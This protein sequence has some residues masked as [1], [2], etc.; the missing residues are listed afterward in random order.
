MKTSASWSFEFTKLVVMSPDRIFYLMKWQST[1]VCLVLSWKSR[2]E[3]MCSAAWL[4]QIS[5]IC[6]ISP[7]WS[8]LK[9][10]LIEISSYVMDAMAQYFASVLEIV[11]LFWTYIPYTPSYF[12]LNKSHVLRKIVSTAL[13]F[14]YFFCRLSNY[15]YIIC[16]KHAFL[17]LCKR[18]KLR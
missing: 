7:N 13:T 9:S 8:S 6:L 2:L 18:I 5:A 12:Y 3:A 11:H 1:S 14:H 4:S 15:D 10:C 16:K 17:V